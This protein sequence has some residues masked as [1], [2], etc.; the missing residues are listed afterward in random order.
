MSIEKLQQLKLDKVKPERLQEQVKGL[1][2]DHNE[3]DDKRDFE[4][5]AKDSIER[6]YILVEKLSPNAIVQETEAKEK[7]KPETKPRA[8]K[9]SKTVKKELDE[10]SEDIKLCR[11]KIR[12]YNEEKRQG[13]PK[14][15][16][17]TRH[18][19]IKKHFIAIANLI[20]QKHKNNLDVQKEAE[21]VLLRAHRGIMNAYKMNTIR[22][23]AGEKAIKEK[24]DDMEEKTTK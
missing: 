1:L 4:A 21:K 24:Y 5:M 3:A 18:E 17:P 13:Q 14:K 16:K 8:E 2:E 22:A 20:P 12:K 19:K 7:K 10:L 9:K 15:P 11:A 23:E 6:A